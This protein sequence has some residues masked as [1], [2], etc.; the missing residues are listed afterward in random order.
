M[1]T[2]HLTPSQFDFV[3]MVAK[4]QLRYE[5]I[6]AEQAEVLRTNQPNFEVAMTQAQQSPLVDRSGKSWEPTPD[7]VDEYLKN[8]DDICQLLP[9]DFDEFSLSQG[10]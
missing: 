9:Q 8:C 7:N 10:S 1:T 4:E 3:E 2:M 6:F 5:T